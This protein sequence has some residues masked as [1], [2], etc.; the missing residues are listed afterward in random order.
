M[1][2][3]SCLPSYIKCGEVYQTELPN[4]LEKSE[5]P[6][7]LA[8][9]N[10][11]TKYIPRPFVLVKF[12]EFINFTLL[13]LNPKLNITY[14]LVRKDVCSEY[15]QILQE[16]E[17]GL[18]SLE[19]LEIANL[20]TNQPT[21][22]SYCDCLDENIS[23]RI[24]YRLEIIQIET[25]NVKSYGLNN[26]SITAT[27]IRGLHGCSKNYLPYIKCGKVF[28]PVLPLH[29]TKEDEPIVLTQLTINIES[30]NNACV[31]I[32][33]S[34]FITSVLKEGRFNNLTFRLVKTCSD[35]T[36]TVLKE[37]PF[38]RVFVNDTNIKEPLVYNYCECLNSKFNLS[39]TY[40]IQLVEAELSK[41]SFYNISQKSMTA[42]AY[43]GKD[44]QGL[45]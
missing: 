18:E 33:F 42:Q 29:L 13:G 2:I 1:S 23:N 5:P 10:V 16:W 8:E 19:M 6:I 39:C 17:F 45:C 44:Q 38:R 14:R 24:I 15:A 34:S 26:K 28:N 4:N 3:K 12:S 21:V 43:L 20:D 41:E 25:N 9:V 30:N 36:T 31:L 7:V 27:V 35:C 22:L 40:T 32:N 37:W 11:N